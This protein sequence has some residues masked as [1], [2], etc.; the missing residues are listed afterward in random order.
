MANIGATRRIRKNVPMRIAAFTSLNEVL[1]TDADTQMFP[2]NLMGVGL[3]IT[4]NCPIACAHCYN[5]SGPK[6][7]LFLDVDVIRRSLKIMCAEFPDL[8][9]V[10]IT[11]GEPLSHPNFDDIAKSIRQLGLRVSVVTSGWHFLRAHHRKELE[12]LDVDEIAFS[13]DRFH[14]KF[15]QLDEIVQIANSAV[16]VIGHVIIKAVASSDSEADELVRVLDDSLHPDIL[17]EINELSGIGRGKNIAESNGTTCTRNHPVDCSSDF[18][19]A[20]INYDGRIY[21]CCSLGSFSE[22]IELCTLNDVI[23]KGSL[24]EFYLGNQNVS[25]LFSRQWFGGG[26][27]KK[28][29]MCKKYG[30]KP[31]NEASEKF[32]NIREVS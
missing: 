2:P 30:G 14:S 17:I 25:T 29:E 10:S 27:T 8:R 18:A 21:P 1:G 28:C 6:G 31:I 7:G 3:V 11:G 4:N 32:P 5:H 22:G 19:V 23:E 24:R 15:L 20:A 26:P 9:A 12:Q 13:Y 16:E